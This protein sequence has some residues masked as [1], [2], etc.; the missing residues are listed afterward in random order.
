MK[1]K[2][3]H[4][5]PE[6]LFA[7]LSGSLFVAFGLFIFTELSFLTGGAAGLTLILTHLVDFSFGQLYFI[8]NLP[9]YWLAF[10]RMGWRFTLNTFISVSTVSVAT[11]VLTYFVALDSIDSV[12]G[13][14]FGG[15]LIGT[16]ILIMFRHV[17]S[18]G[19]L[20][21]LSLYLQD[22]L[23]INAGK[24]QLS[25]DVS[26]LLIGYFLV[27]IEILLLSLLGALALNL[28]IGINHKP[29]RYQIT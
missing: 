27:S 29:G 24:T 1:P 25:V 12:F 4:S 28:V 2:V 26:I 9:F 6:D 5:I 13:A 3:H 20:G 19:G 21:I 14:I 16:G 11:D 15:L 23:G 10:R 7:L 22:K 8:I 17:S 18:L